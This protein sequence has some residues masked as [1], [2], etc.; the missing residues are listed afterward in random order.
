MSNARDRFNPH[1]LSMNNAA[2]MNSAGKIRSARAVAV[3]AA[4]I[5]VMV[6]AIPARAADPVF[7]AGSLIGLVPPAGMVTSRG[8]TGFEDADKNA[9]IL[10]AALPPTAYSEIEKTLSADA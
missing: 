3:L 5:A 4:L 2:K 10:I 8:F 1:R 6:F 9:G 7:P